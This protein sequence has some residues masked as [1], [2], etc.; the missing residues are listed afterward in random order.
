MKKI[1]I[2]LS[3]WLFLLI[4]FS[5]WLDT[6]TS[7]IWKIEYQV[8][9]CNSVFGCKIW[10]FN[11]LSTTVWPESTVW[12]TEDSNK[13]VICTSNCTSSIN[14]KNLFL[15]LKLKWEWVY[16]ITFFVYDN[17]R[18]WKVRLCNWNYSSDVFNWTAPWN[19]SK[20][21]VTYKV[22]KTHP[23]ILGT[24]S[25]STTNFPY[26]VESSKKIYVW[27][28][29]KTTNIKEYDANISNFSSS[30]E[31]FLSKW[32]NWDIKDN[33]SEQNWTSAKLKTIYYS[34]GNEQITIKFNLQNYFN[35][36]NKYNDD[37]WTISKLS[38][39]ELLKPD[40]STVKQT[41]N[42]VNTMSL[43]NW[44]TTSKIKNLFWNNVDEKIFYFRIYDKA[45]NYSET[46][47]YLVKDTTAP[48]TLNE[49]LDTFTFSGWTEKMF[50][51]T[52]KIWPDASIPSKFF[53]TDDNLKL[54][55]DISDKKEWNDNTHNSWI[56]K[57]KFK[58][59]KVDSCWNYKDYIFTPTDG[60][61]QESWTTIQQS[62][63]ITHDFSK[64]DMCLQDT[65]NTYRYYRSHIVSIDDDNNE[66]TDKI[67]D[68]VWNCTTIAPLVFR[69]VANKIDN[70]KTRVSIWSWSLVNWRMLANWKSYYLFIFILRD[71]YNNK[72]VPVYSQED[73][74]VIKN[75]KLTLD[76]D[77][78]MYLNQ[79]EKNSH[80][81]VFKENVDET[82]NKNS[83]NGE[84]TW[85]FYIEENP[86]WA[87]HP[88][89]VYKFKI[90]SVVPTSEYYPWE[91]Q[92]TR[93]I[94]KNINFLAKDKTNNGNMVK[95]NDI[96]QYNINK[97]SWTN[98][99]FNLNKWHL[100]YSITVNKYLDVNYWNYWKIV[101]SSNM[102]HN[103]KNFITKTSNKIKFWFASPVLVWFDE[104]KA[105][106]EWVKNVYKYNIWDFDKNSIKPWN[107]ELWEYWHTNSV[108]DF[109]QWTWS[110]SKKLSNI[111][112]K[113]SW[114]LLSLETLDLVNSL[115]NWK[116]IISKFTKISVQP[117]LSDFVDA[118]NTH[119]AVW[120]KLVY[121]I[122]NHKV[123]LPSDGRWISNS[124]VNPNIDNGFW[125][126]LSIFNPDGWFSDWSSSSYDD[127]ELAPLVNDIKILWNASTK[128][129]NKSIL[130]WEKKL[131]VWWDIKKW[132]IRNDIKKKF[133]QIMWWNSFDNWCTI[134]N[135]SNSCS[136]F[137]IK[138]E[139][140][141]P[142]KWNLIFSWDYNINWRQTFVVYWNIYINGNLYK[143]SKNSLLTL[144]SFNDDWFSRWG[145]IF[146]NL[147][148]ISSVK[149][150]IYINPKVTNIDAYMYAQGS[151]LSYNWTK[152]YDGSNITDTAGDKN[153]YNQLYVR[154][155]IISTNTIWWSRLADTDPFNKRFPWF[156]TWSSLSQ[157]Q[158]QAFDLIYLRRY[159]LVDD[160]YYW[161]TDSKKIP[162]L[163]VSIA[164]NTW[165]YN[166]NKPYMWWQ[167]KCQFAWSSV[168]CNLDDNNN[169]KNIPK[170]W[171]S[172]P[173]YIEYDPLFNI[174]PPVIFT[175]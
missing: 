131:N 50:Y 146:S 118:N 96:W 161:G 15:N 66:Y 72:I 53:A 141:F 117:A 85:Q 122:G 43:N 175:K 32:W 55:F 173:L 136:S 135:G 29:N 95:K 37:G 70:N 35:N 125:D 128:W 174:N 47:V 17:V 94:L 74:Q 41:W 119:I 158:A 8:K 147:V 39:I 110:I 98:I 104:L 63:S 142:I 19:C 139:K 92:N 13:K 62:F 137:T 150:F 20:L 34:D 144:V 81:W 102:F 58:L 54:K 89:S 33:P 11:S 91:W 152:I 1:L 162:Y 88:N 106:S 30:N 60:L 170:N 79:I 149:W 140:I 164:S 69:V 64:V 97:F 22:D 148:N 127:S 126:S 42:L 153:I 93:L 116:K 169:L 172:Y 112:L 38:K 168:N 44:F 5:F 132:K 145:L 3:V 14:V 90:Y 105:I 82:D 134:N 2:L 165:D 130:T 51:T 21:V 143:W 9:W 138:W 77:N 83:F 103:N 86:T 10:Y 68:K 61:N 84:L 113:W 6:S 120:T 101:D 167:K 75:S 157:N 7:W 57:F 124:V 163:P 109:Y 49:F 18:Y 166:S 100:S 25:A 159:M 12:F 23:N 27:K 111:W 26:F 133:V 36:E 129:A 154:W 107:T 114:S 31:N 87:D 48:I 151:L 160:S 171:I 46:L 28:S 121:K 40:H 52:S 78:T 115:N 71:K 4:W 123:L 16:T 45:W 67:C 155:W 108:Y 65:N 73:T 56:L 80:N 156:I 59:E 99:D 24:D 76:F